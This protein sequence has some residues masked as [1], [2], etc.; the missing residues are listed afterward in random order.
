VC[1]S[2][3]VGAAANDAVPGINNRA[4]AE[5]FVSVTPLQMELTAYG[6]MEAL[7]NWLGK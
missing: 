1:L 7:A 2:G 5:E 4:I 6:M 3:P